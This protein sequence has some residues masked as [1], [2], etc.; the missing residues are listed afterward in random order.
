MYFNWFYFSQKTKFLESR[1]G[2]L[3]TANIW[4]KNPINLLNQ[5]QTEELDSF[6]VLQKPHIVSKLCIE[7]KIQ[8]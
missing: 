5:P 3:E 2:G 7:L 8:R 4:D 6:N 1:N